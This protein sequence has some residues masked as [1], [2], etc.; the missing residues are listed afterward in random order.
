MAALQ[1]LV[2]YERV[3][4]ARQGQ[5]GLGLEAQRKVIEDFAASRGAEVLARFT[6]VESGR[7]ADR[8]ELA[9]ALH[10]AKV[11]GSTLVIAKLDRLSRNAAFLLA[12][13]D[14]GVRFIAVDMP[15]ANDLTVGIMALVAQAEREAISR[16]T[17]E[18]LAVAK[19]RGV[20]LG[21]PNG[22]A[23]LK[24]A[25]KG[26]MALRAAVSANAAA[27]A[28]DLAPVLADIQA[29]GHTSLRAIAAE[30]TARGI[31][32]RRGGT[33]GVGNVR[34]LVGRNSTWANMPR[35]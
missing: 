25:G 13:R 31:R 8:P 2:A 21:N 32:T 30:L 4:T 27:F 17:K 34:G 10:L 35:P 3:S 22:A 15:E 33:W 12:L 29:A 9:K 1:R 26:G 23:A 28:E 11:T 14:S 18:A 6:E 20:K 16:R 5:S 24:R 19:A 7:K